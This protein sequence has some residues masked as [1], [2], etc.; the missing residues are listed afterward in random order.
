MTKN[1]L[2]V[3]DRHRFS[4][5]FFFIAIQCSFFLYEKTRKQINIRQE[6]QNEMK[7]LSVGDF[8]MTGFCS[9]H[10]VFS[11]WW[12]PISFLNSPL[13]IVKEFDKWDFRLR[14]LLG[15]WYSARILF[16]LAEDTD[17]I[18]PTTIEVTVT[19]ENL[20]MPAFKRETTSLMLLWWH[21][22]DF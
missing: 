1:S 6:L 2:V 14:K 15:E 7:C 4:I 17:W 10:V 12:G 13:L 8:F 11:I 16:P 5:H 18:L 19:R 21:L 3:V 9:G 20:E 22:F